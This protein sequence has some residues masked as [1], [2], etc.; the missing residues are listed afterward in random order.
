M[1][2]STHEP[3]WKEEFDKMFIDFCKNEKSYKTEEFEVFLS[4]IGAQTISYDYGAFG[5]NLGNKFYILGYSDK[6]EQNK[7]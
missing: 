3:L 4:I 5:E 2:A 1:I 7:N 6:Y